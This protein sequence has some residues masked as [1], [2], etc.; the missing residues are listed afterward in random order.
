MQPHGRTPA[1]RRFGTDIRSRPFRDLRP[2]EISDDVHLEVENFVNGV[3]CPLEGF[4]VRA[5]VDSM[6]RRW[7]LTDGTVF[8][9]P[10]VCHVD[11][12]AFR[13]VRV[14]ETVLLTVRGAAVARMRVTEKWRMDRDR[15]IRAMFR[16]RDP[17][18]PGVAWA[19]RIHDTMLAGPVIPA[20]CGNH[21]YRSGAMTPAGVR[22]EI[23]RRGWR[24]VAAFSTG[25]VPHRAHEYL[26]RV[27]LEMV[28]GIL[29]H[30]LSYVG[31][32]EKFS[33][34]LIGACYRALM[35]GYFPEKNILFSFLPILPRSAGPRSSVMQAVIRRNFGCTHQ[36][37]GRDHEG[38]RDVFGT[39][40]SQQA[41]LRFPELGIRMLAFREPCY[42]LKCGGMVTERNCRHAGRRIRISGTALRDMLRTGRD[43]PAY[44]LRDEVLKRLRKG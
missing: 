7:R 32:T 30:P 20:G 40:E 18:H 28:D 11:A 31:G 17:R 14:P 41:F 29:V 4:P 12:R 6:L 19:G 13:E 16:T 1:I 44:Y 15:F 8:P 5:D 38:F 21:F 25:N 26:L 35:N 22:A 3:Y 39:Y 9:V 10:P 33:R 43:V 24:T 27:A 23:R 34:R 36:I 2:I 37:I 42:C